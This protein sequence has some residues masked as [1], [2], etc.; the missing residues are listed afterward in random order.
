MERHIARDAMN[1]EDWLKE[2]KSGIGASDAAALLGLSKWKTNVQLFEEK[3]GRREQED[4]G[5]KECVKYGKEAEHYLRELFKLD[6]PQY[7]VTYDEFKM[8]HNADYPF[9]FATLDGELAEMD[10]SEPMRLIKRSGVLEIKTADIQNGAQAQKW[11]GNSMPD[12]YYIQVLHQFLATGYDFAILKAQLK[13]NFGDMRIVTVHRTIERSEVEN[14]LEYLL[15]KEIEFW[16]CVKNDKK[17][18][19]ILP[20]I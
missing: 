6:F 2:R 18:A 13:Y 7:L 11:R 12:G 17:P 8:I 20:G 14:D 10:N 15:S 16:D 9:I 5:E 19:L 4:I 3:T 1:R